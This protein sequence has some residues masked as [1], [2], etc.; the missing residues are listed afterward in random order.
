MLQEHATGLEN[1]I[2][3]VW[4]ILFRFL[5]LAKLRNNIIVW[6]NEAFTVQRLILGKNHDFSKN[7]KIFSKIPESELSNGFE[8][9]FSY[10]P[11]FKTVKHY[12]GMFSRPIS[13]RKK[14]FWSIFEIRENSLFSPHGPKWGL[15][16]KNSDFVLI[17]SFS[18]E[19]F[20]SMLRGW[21][22][23]SE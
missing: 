10:S 9:C 17:F 6:K 3:V 22:I 4:V 20:R 23:L 1:Q 11:H 13:D 8:L 5:K 21:N 18:P 12:I 7:F 19:C 14:R 15:Q 16:Y 2:W